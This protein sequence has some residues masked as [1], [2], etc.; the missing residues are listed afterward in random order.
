MAC[1]NDTVACSASSSDAKGKEVGLRGFSIII[2]GGDD[3]VQHKITLLGRQ[4][5]M[6]ISL[7]ER[8]E[9]LIS[10]ALPLVAQ[11]Y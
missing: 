2:D 7:D 3:G 10:F 9:E 6:Q 5:L 1:L 8:I 4:F 11:S